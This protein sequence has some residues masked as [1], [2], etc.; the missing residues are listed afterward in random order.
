MAALVRSETGI[1]PRL[2][3]GRMGEFSVWLDDKLILKRS[4]LK[5]PTDE[6]VLAAVRSALQRPG[7]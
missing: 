4:W 1:E 3:Q 5:L 6:Q 7:V 2:V